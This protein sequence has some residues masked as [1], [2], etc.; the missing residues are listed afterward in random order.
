MIT[1]KVPP[2]PP[3]VNPA[4]NTKMFKQ[5]P[6][7]TDTTTKK[8]DTKRKLKKLKPFSLEDDIKFTS[9]ILII[10]QDEL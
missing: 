10:Y 5:I 8:I 6:A 7:T 4:S 1:A 9:I 3:S 2:S